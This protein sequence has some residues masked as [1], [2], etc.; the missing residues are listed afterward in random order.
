[1][2]WPWRFGR[3]RAER[4]G[5]APGPE[6]APVPGREAGAVPVVHRSPGLA[7]ALHGLDP[8]RPC[9][10]LDL[11]PAMS[12]TVAFFAEYRCRLGVVDLLA[13]L[14]VARREAAGTLLMQAQRSKAQR[15]A[16]RRAQEAEARE[17][18]V[19]ARVLD[20]LL[21]ADQDGLDL[22]L[23]WDVLDHL[24]QPA[25]QA[26]V[27]RLARLCRP[28]ARM[29]A[30]V[31]ISREQ[32]LAPIRFGIA[33]TD[34]LEYRPGPLPPSHGAVLSPAAVEL[35]LTGFETV[36]SVVLRH[37]LREVVVVRG[38]AWPG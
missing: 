21:P 16:A 7:A 12:S 3:A 30:M 11:G 33:G 37:G 29:L 15:S 23:A 2:Q 35:L 10:V 34:R 20:E 1:M 9:R 17:T 6:P 8:R 38:A 24:E 4:P 36:H 32:A 28:G 19:V 5:E 25:A 22:V 18:A 14:A 13:N 31:A 27:R 26:L